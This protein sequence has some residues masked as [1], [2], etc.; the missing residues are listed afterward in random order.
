MKKL[1]IQYGLLVIANVM[2][3]ILITVSIG[4]YLLWQAPIMAAMP[5]LLALPGVLLQPWCFLMLLVPRFFLASPFVI[6]LVTF[7]VYRYLNRKVWFKKLI[8]RLPHLTISQCSWT[9]G[10]V[11][12][13]ALCVMLARFKDI[14][15]L[16]TGLS[17]ATYELKNGLPDLKNEGRFYQLP[18]FMDKEGLWQVNLSQAQLNRVVEQLG[19][20]SIAKSQLPSGFNGMPPYWWR[21]LHNSTTQYFSTHD[22]PFDPTISGG[23]QAIAVW[24]PG[25]QYLYLWYKSIF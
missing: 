4:L 11:V 13:A 15:P 9:F 17:S 12:V 16:K 25:D 8:R 6:S 24:N 2:I 1:L 23:F 10:S 14:P 21:P 18:S 3:S 5:A 7:G 22:V 19:L 20:R